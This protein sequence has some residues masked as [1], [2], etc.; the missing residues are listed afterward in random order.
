MKGAAP[1][2]EVARESLHVYT[3]PI[4]RCKEQEQEA[5][6]E[7]GIIEDRLGVLESTVRSIQESFDSKFGQLESTLGLLQQAIAT[8]T[9][10]R[11][12]S[13]VP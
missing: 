10:L 9:E 1:S 4:V 6:E 13:K 5:E 3:H 7:P 2:K 12:S 11:N 8:L